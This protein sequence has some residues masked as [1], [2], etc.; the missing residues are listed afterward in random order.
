M[1]IHTYIVVN[2][3][4][5]A[6]ANHDVTLG[7]ATIATSRFGNDASLQTRSD[8]GHGLVLDLVI[9]SDG[10]LNPDDLHPWPRNLGC[11]V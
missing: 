6:A 11:S 2:D 10:S 3:S 8:L 9:D 4:S 5:L 7:Q 1:R